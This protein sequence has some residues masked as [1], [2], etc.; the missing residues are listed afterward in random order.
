M[1]QDSL[2]PSLDPCMSL[3][4]YM[5]LFNILASLCCWAE[6]FNLSYSYSDSFTNLGLWVLGLATSNINE[7]PLQTNESKTLFLM[8]SLPYYC[9]PGLA[10]TRWDKNLC[11]KDAGCA[12][13]KI[14]VR[15]PRREVSRVK[16]KIYY[17]KKVDWRYLDYTHSSHPYTIRLEIWY[18][19]TLLAQQQYGSDLKAI[20][21]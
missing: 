1:G 3:T 5:W 17:D 14:T 8:T 18:L 12:G 2:S 11:A 4:C 13:N 7:S 10:G 21:W 9:I 6:W 15:K 16:A 19:R 20:L